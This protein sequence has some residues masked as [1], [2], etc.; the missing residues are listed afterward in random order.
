M[1]YKEKYEQALERARDLMTNQNPPA[2]DKHLIEMVF[3]ELKENENGD[4]RI[5]KELINFLTSPFVN[6]NITDEKVV[7]WIAWLEKQGEK[8]AENVEIKFCEGD[9]VVSNQNGKV[10]TVGTTYYVTGDGEDICLHDTDGN[11]LWTNRDDLDKNYHL[12]TSE[13]TKK[14]DANK[15]IEWVNSDEVIEWLEKTIRSHAENYGV[16]KETRLTLPYNSIEDLINDFKED[17]GLY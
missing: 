2:F 12:W 3:P 1:D 10:Y 5:R 6:E 13:D 8:P 14:L 17:F 7:P 15:V 9:K 16:Y 4:E 11:H